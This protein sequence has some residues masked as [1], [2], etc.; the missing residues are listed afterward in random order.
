MYRIGVHCV[1][2]KL[3][4]FLSLIRK[5]R[6]RIWDFT[7]CAIETQLF[8]ESQFKFADRMIAVE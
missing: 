3:F 2:W 7:M 5:I 6:C 4:C 8:H 1:N